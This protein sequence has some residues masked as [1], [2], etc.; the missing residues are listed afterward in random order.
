MTVIRKMFNNLS[1]FKNL[2]YNFIKEP[3]KLIIKDSTSKNQEFIKNI[4]AA[5]SYRKEIMNI[6]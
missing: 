5:V 6:H 4:D 1:G 2:N 3:K